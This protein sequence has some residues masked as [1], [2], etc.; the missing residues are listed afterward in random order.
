[1]LGD[2]LSGGENVDG[3]HGFMIDPRRARCRDEKKSPNSSGGGQDACQFAINSGLSTVDRSGESRKT[4]KIL[5]T[6]NY[7]IMKLNKLSKTT[8]DIITRK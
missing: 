5:L 4:K 3:V 6:N 8:M 1:M 7:Y 2:L